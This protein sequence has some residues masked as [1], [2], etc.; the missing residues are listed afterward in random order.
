MLLK[1]RIDRVDESENGIAVIDYK[2]QGASVLREKAQD[3]GEDV[4]LAVYELLLGEDVFE[5]AFLSIDKEVRLYPQQDRRAHENLERLA[6][7]FEEM[8]AGSPLPAQGL[9]SV[10]RHC[11]MRGLCRK[12]HWE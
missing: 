9:E 4:Q 1:G 2:T 3:A 8:H 7:I 5:A 11:D 6:T 10:C 12:D